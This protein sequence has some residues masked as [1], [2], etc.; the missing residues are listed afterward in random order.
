MPTKCWKWW[1]CKIHDI[2]YIRLTD[3]LAKMYKATHQQRRLSH[4]VYV[5]H[6]TG[7]YDVTILIP[8]TTTHHRSHDDIKN[9]GKFVRV[10]IKPL[11]EPTFLDY[12]KA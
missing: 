9:T 3:N 1:Y 5:Y 7:S 11:S 12:L 10:P 4:R 6:I 2:L 8:C